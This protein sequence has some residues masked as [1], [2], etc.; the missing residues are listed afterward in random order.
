MSNNAP[1]WYVQQWKDGVT[2]HYQSKGFTLKNCTSPPVKMDGEKMY[3]LVAGVGQAE[4]N[5]A[6]GSTAIPFNSGR[7]KVEVTTSKSRAFSEIYEDDLDQMTV[8][9]MAVENKASAMALG[10]VHDKTII[11]ALEAGAVNEV[12]AYNVTAGP[13]ELLKMRATLMAQDVAVDE[14][15]VFCAVDSVIWANL[16]TF[17]QFASADYVGPALPYIQAGLAKTWSGIHVFAV[18]DSLLPVAAGPTER[19]F[20][21]WA[22]EA[23]GFGW[24]RNLTGNVVWDNRKDCWTHNM[25]MR[26]G[27]KVILPKGIV[28]G[29]SDYDLA[30]ITA[31]Q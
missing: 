31:S 20:Y 12:G 9:E 22:R 5:V 23:I 30:N 11:T 18:S 13:A 17:K 8:D 26:I 2:H 19:K 1:T 3:F 15:Y 10:R 28:R 29:K 24:V 16:M 27:S 7:E 6:R 21:M 4:E 14:E 25:R